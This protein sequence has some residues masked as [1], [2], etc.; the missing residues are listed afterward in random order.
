MEEDSKVIDANNNSK[1]TP[2]EIKATDASSLSTIDKKVIK[3][4]MKLTDSQYE[5][6]HAP[7]KSICEHLSTE[8]IVTIIDF[9][10]ILGAICGIA[11][12]NASHYPSFTRFS[13]SLGYIFSLTVLDFGS[14]FDFEILWYLVGG[15]LILY[16]WFSFTFST[17]G[18]PNI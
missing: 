18:H 13:T 17:S 15:V 1:I 14:I 4:W 5:K 6:I 3:K 11:T 7:T 16:Q 2:N 8:H 9:C 12:S 10:Q